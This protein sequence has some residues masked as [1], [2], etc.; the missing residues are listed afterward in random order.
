MINN[1]LDNTLFFR[2]QFFP[3]IKE[4][5]VSRNTPRQVD[6]HARWG[7]SHLF[8]ARFLLALAEVGHP[9]K[10]RKRA[11]ARVLRLDVG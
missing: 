7:H 9:E 2:E 1:T 8:I 11:R 3:P 10:K 6:M 4:D 5:N